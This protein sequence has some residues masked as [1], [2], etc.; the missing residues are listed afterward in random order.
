MGSERGR[1]TSYPVDSVLVHGQVAAAWFSNNR[2]R[3]I[4]PIRL[5]GGRYVYIVDLTPKARE[6]TLCTFT[7]SP[8]PS[9]GEVVRFVLLFLLED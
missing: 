7:Q 6:P 2:N 8:E 5:E 4:C 3:R 9:L 1:V